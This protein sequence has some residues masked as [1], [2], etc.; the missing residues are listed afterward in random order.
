MYSALNPQGRIRLG[1]AARVKFGEPA[2]PGAESIGRASGH[3]RMVATGTDNVI[4]RH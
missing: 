1:R 2:G 3:F 4:V